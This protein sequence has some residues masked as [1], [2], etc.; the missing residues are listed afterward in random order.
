MC[1]L[2]TVVC[3]KTTGV[4]IKVYIIQSL[5]VKSSTLKGLYLDN[6]GHTLYL[7]SCR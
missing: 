1:A 5:S 4:E 3:H 7:L 6:L 2:L